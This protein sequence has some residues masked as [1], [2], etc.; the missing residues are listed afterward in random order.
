MSR[1]QAPFQILG[2]YHLRENRYVQVTALFSNN[3][4]RQNRFL[5]DR[6]PYPKTWRNCL[7]ETAKIQYLS[8]RI[9]RLHRR[10]LGICIFQI[11]IRC[12]L[13]QHHIIFLN[14]LHQCLSAFCRNSAPAGILKT[15]NHINQ[16]YICFCAQN[17]I[18]LFRNDTFLVHRCF[19]EGSLIHFEGL[20]SRQISWAFHHN[21][22][23]FVD[24]CLSNQ[25]QSLLRA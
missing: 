16:L 14:H 12:I 17:A 10:I 13:N 5:G 9:H 25:I 18:Q 20:Q 2:H 22:V 19:D 15:G 8:C 11:F 21:L 24:E 7:G 1:H 3:H 6:I 23:I 4:F